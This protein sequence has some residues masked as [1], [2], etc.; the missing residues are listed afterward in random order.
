MV[1]MRVRLHVRVRVCRD[2]WS[3]KYGSI[4]VRVGACMWLTRFGTI[5]GF[6]LVHVLRVT[7]FTSP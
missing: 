6:R 7:A 5:L 1:S 2:V 3:T 4:L